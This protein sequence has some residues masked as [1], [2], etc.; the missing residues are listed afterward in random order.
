MHIDAGTL[1][2]TDITAGRY[3]TPLISHI[4]GY[5]GFKVIH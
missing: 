2:I 3:N 5:N 1:P 4:I